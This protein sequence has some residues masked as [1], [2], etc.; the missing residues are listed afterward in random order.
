MELAGCAYL[1]PSKR[2]AGAL[3]SG[4]AGHLLVAAGSAGP[5]VEEWQAGLPA[6]AFRPSDWIFRECLRQPD[7]GADLARWRSQGA[8]F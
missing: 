5:A 2:P 3:A 7:R 1:H 4:L 8:A 6:A